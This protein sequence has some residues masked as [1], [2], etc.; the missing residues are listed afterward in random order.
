MY[1]TTKVGDD[2]TLGSGEIQLRDVDDRRLGK[3]VWVFWGHEQYS[4]EQNG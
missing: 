4:C 2:N 3:E 1:A